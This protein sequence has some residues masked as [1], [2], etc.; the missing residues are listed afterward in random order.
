MSASYRYI[1]LNENPYKVS[2]KFRGSIPCG[3]RTG[4]GN[5]FE[6]IP[7][8]KLETRDATEI[9]FSREFGPI[10]NHAVLWP[11]EDAK[12]WKFSIRFCIFWEKNDP[13]R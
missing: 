4:Q 8:V 12:S 13:L 7:T 2:V 11:S 6:L 10:C 1:V 5:D 3:E 9:Y